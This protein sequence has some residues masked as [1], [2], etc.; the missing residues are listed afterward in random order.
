M[1]LI[2]KFLAQKLAD[3]ASISDENL[4]LSHQA[5]ELSRHGRITVKEM[6]EGQKLEAVYR[7]KD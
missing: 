3:A 5:I 1:S 6:L 2:T 4:S 7:F